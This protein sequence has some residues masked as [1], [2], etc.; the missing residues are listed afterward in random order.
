MLDAILADWSTA[1]RDDFLNALTRFNDTLDAWVAR[2]AF[3][4]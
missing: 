1:E 4:H 2:D 3:P